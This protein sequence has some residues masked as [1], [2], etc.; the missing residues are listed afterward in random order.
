MSARSVAQ[1]DDDDDLDRIALTIMCLLVAQTMPA[2]PPTG[3]R[4]A[5]EAAVARFMNIMQNARSDGAAMT[6]DRLG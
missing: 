6:A 4:D 3:P 1:G 5:V 2:S